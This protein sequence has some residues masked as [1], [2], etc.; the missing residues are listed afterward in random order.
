MFFLFVRWDL[1]WCFGD[2]WAVC[3]VFEFGSIQ[4]LKGKILVDGIDFGDVVAVV[5]VDF[6][7]GMDSWFEI[8]ESMV[9]E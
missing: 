1:V 5:G 6:W 8:G 4:V 9:L 3:I 7:V 2:L